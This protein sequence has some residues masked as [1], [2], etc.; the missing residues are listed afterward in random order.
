M[1]NEQSQTRP[2]GARCIGSDS[3]TADQLLFQGDRL[4]RELREVKAAF[5]L[6]QEQVGSRLPTSPRLPARCSASRT[7]ILVIVCRSSFRT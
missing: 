6:H 2:G 5:A 3:T 4:E 7:P 1:G